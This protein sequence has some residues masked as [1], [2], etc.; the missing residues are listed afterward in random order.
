MRSKTAD[1]RRRK[2]ALMALFEPWKL[3]SEVKEALLSAIPRPLTTPRQWDLEVFQSGRCPLMI[4]HYH[5]I[6]TTTCVDARQPLNS[7][8]LHLRFH[9]LSVLLRRSQP[10]ECFCTDAWEVCL[11]KEWHKWSS[12]RR[13]TGCGMDYGDVLIRVR[14]PFWGSTKFLDYGVYVPLGFAG[15][16]WTQ[17]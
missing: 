3:P 15:A 7:V 14:G 8:Q 1:S 13:I 9:W 16:G 5:S 12:A 10:S 2:T 11:R 4:P 6:R 17:P